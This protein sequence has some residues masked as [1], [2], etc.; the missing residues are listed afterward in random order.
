MRTVGHLYAA[1]FAAVLLLLVVPAASAAEN[2]TQQAP[3]AENPQVGYIQINTVP[4]GA[5]VFV[6]RTK[7]NGL[8]PLTI[9]VPAMVPQEIQVNK[10]GYAT[11]RKVITAP[12]NG[13]V[14]YTFT[15]RT[16]PGVD[17]PETERP[18]AGRS[19]TAPVVG[20]GETALPTAAEADA[21]GSPL[22]PLAVLAALGLA[23]LLVSLRR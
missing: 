13:T 2:A 14:P 7:M 23:G 17:R 6:N 20:A 19:P 18:G 22:S 12:P 9:R 16:L 8:T 21:P 3:G 1:L 11:E 10:Y 15:L 5:T 4:D